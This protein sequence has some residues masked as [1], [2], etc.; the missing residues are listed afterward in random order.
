MTPDKPSQEFHLTPKGW[1]SGTSWN[2]KTIQGEPIDRPVNS[3]ETW[4]EEMVQPNLFCSDI[5]SWTLIW[6]DRSMTDSER[7]KVRKKFPKPAE[8]FPDRFY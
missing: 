3:I 1:I 5:Y 4:L 7:R 6:F 8:T 2:F